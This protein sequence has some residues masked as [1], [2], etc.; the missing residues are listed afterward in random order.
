MH[1]NKYTFIY[2]TVLSIITAVL[3]AFA[4]EG[5]KPFQDANISL[6]QKTSIL[7]SIR[8]TEMERKA[9]E[10]IYTAHI[11]EL[12]VNSAGE[13]VNGVKPSEIVIKEE[14][15]KPPKERRMA[16]YI[17]TADD[18]KKYY[19]V[20]LLG[21]GLWGP[22]WGYLSI[23]SDFNTV[24]GAFFGHKSETPGLGAEIAEAPFQQQFQ[25]K[26]IMSEDHQFVSVNVVKKTAKTAYG[27]EHRVDGVSGGTV[28]STGTDKMLKNCIEPYLSYFE[29]IKEGG[30]K[31]T[32]K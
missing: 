19:I 23:E 8:S 29:K 25:G 11:R 22:I 30:D 16:L 3:L 14:L 24:Y 2:A 12:V 13:E 4:S 20:P 10:K 32:L 5:L 26:K 9:I 1:S 21:V 15:A 7:R 31:M 27:P 28:T 6:D 17:Y 18:N